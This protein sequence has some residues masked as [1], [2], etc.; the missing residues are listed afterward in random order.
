M[1]VTNNPLMKDEEGAIYIEDG[2]FNDVLIA[3]RDR[4]HLGY[5]LISHP[6]FASHGMMN[7]PYRTV[8]MGDTPGKPD[9]DQMQIIESAI[10]SYNKAIGHHTRIPEHDGDYALLDRS[11]YLSAFEESELIRRDF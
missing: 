4:V 9:M 1:I 3:V 6:L 10:I 7:C 8:I 11:L 5:D 2:S